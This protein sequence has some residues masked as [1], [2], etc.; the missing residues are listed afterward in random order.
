MHP[1]Q[2]KNEALRMFRINFRM[3][4]TCYL[5]WLNIRGVDPNGHENECPP[6]AQHI[7]VI[8]NSIAIEFQCSNPLQFLGGVIS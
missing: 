5:C 4:T 6:K 3:R 2:M 8:A 1:I 7:P